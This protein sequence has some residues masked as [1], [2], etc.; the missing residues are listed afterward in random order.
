MASTSVRVPRLKEP[1]GNINPNQRKYRQ[2]LSEIQDRRLSYQKNNAEPPSTRE[3]TAC[4]REE[5]FDAPYSTMALTLKFS[6]VATASPPPC[7]QHKSARDSGG[8]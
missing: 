1:Q 7:R 8:F 2:I 4:L 6:P 3:W 5:K